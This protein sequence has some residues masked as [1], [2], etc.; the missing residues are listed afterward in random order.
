MD[1]KKLNR[2]MLFML[3][4]IITVLTALPVFAGTVTKTVYTW[5]RVGMSST[6]R[7]GGSFAGTQNG[8]A[9]FKGIIN[10]VHADGK[11]NY[12]TTYCECEIPPESIEANE[13]VTLKV[14][15]HGNVIRNDENRGIYM[16]CKV[17]MAESGLDYDG[18]LNG[19][20]SF[21][22]SDFSWG[23]YAGGFG[24]QEH[25][26]SR[27]MESGYGHSTGDTISIY[28]RC[29]WGLYE[30]KYQ[31]QKPE[32]RTEPDGSEE[33]GGSDGTK[34]SSEGSL[35]VIFGNQTMFFEVKNRKATFL[36]VKNKKVKSVEIPATV[37]WFG[38]AIPVTTVAPGAL[39][40]MKKMTSLTIGKNVKTIGE[41]AFSGC[42]K[43][44]KLTIRTKKL[45]KDTV[46]AN[47]FKGIYKKAEIICPKAKKKAYKKIFLK[48]GMKKT[49]KFK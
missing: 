47:A 4:L 45:T 2:H 34:D 22:P 8:M 28:F 25:T 26:V 41:N 18:T 49:M 32:T 1:M 16:T 19:G 3:I 27:S 46:G 7:S 39:K 42:K 5:K 24:D 14:R 31:L 21:S 17:K 48:K 15:L 44:K 29:S 36:T 35:S 30:W 20:Y 13:T 12:A 11:Q 43:L 23:N 33:P 37:R 9:V 6:T 38:K 40:G 10:D